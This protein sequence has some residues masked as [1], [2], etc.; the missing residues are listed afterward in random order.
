MVELLEM[1]LA[2]DKISS[3]IIVYFLVGSLIEKYT[4]SISK[5]VVLTHTINV[6]VSLCSNKMLRIIN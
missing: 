1:Q 6:S 4:S 5:Q 3:S 2:S